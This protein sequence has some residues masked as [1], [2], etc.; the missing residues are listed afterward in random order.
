MLLIRFTESGYSKSVSPLGFSVRTPALSASKLTWLV[1][2]FVA[3]AGAVTVLVYIPGRG[4]L[5]GY[6]APNILPTDLVES[7]GGGQGVRNDMARTIPS[8]CG[9][10]RQFRY[11]TATS[12][13]YNPCPS[14]QSCNCPVTGYPVFGE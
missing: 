3:C 6:E 9:L 14:T 11:L 8:N 7:T 5:T 13:P 10:A 12:A 2:R 1:G 4:S